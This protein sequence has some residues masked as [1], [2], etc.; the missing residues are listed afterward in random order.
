M[1]KMNRR[2]L[3]K[4]TAC[5]MLLSGLSHNFSFSKSSEKIKPK[6]L[7]PGDKVGLICPATAVT[8]PNDLA[9]AM[10]IIKYYG[11][12][13]VIGDSVKSGSGYKSRTVKERVD[14]LHKMF[15]DKSVKAVFCIRGGYGSAQ[16]L[17]SI[18]YELIRN[19]PKI[20]CG[21]S[22]ITAMLIAIQKLTGLVTFHGP[23]ML[24]AFTT[25]TA[26]YF[27]AIFIN[28]QAP[29]E[30]TNPIHSSGIRNPYPTRTI[31]SGKASG[32][33]VGGNLTKISTTL[34]TPFEIDTKGKILFLEDVGEE[35]YR[36]DRMLTQLRLAGKFK[37]AK[38]IL[39]GDCVDCGFRQFE[40]SR[41]WD[42]TLG[43]ILDNYFSNM[44]IPV[45]SGLLV[46]HSSDQI[47]LP[48]GAE[49]ELDAENCKLTLLE[50]ALI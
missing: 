20:F 9:K 42:Y 12:Q 49:V 8:D 31:V 40:S 32:E 22:D 47:T 3:L 4:I 25:F 36:I 18:D 17:D 33:L 35:P 14:D 24:S 43:E 39:F 13:A 7:E 1:K 46:G 19:N 28:N 6:K 11:L 27:E 2:N 45:F 26:K 41:S 50:N 15:A 44:K 34:G 37:E 29:V 5:S 23:M 10:E 16:I 30:M 38:G 21:Y 48:L